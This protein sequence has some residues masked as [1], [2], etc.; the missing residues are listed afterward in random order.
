[1]LRAR[2]IVLAG[3]LAAGCGTPSYVRTAYDG[4][5]ASLQRDVRAAVAAGKVDRDGVVELARAVARR[6]VRSV[7][8]EYAVERI[9]GSRVCVDTVASELWER[10]RAKDDAGAQALLVLLES[11]RVTRGAVLGDHAR[12]AS[13]AFRAVAARATGTSEHSAL[14][15]SYY[16]D[17]DERVRREALRAAM[18]ARDPR[19]LPAL[20]DA[21][22]LDPAPANRSAAIRALGLVGDEKA[23]L[24]LVDLWAQADS[25]T[26]L[27]I[28]EAWAALGLFDKGGSG[29]LLRL[30]ESRRGLQSVSAASA[31]ARQGE[32]FAKVG[33]AVLAHFVADGTTDERLVAIQV[34][35]LSDPATLAAI[36]QASNSDDRTVAVVAAARLLEDKGRR[37]RAR[38]QLVVWAKGTDG[39]ARQAAAALVAV[40]DPSAAPFLTRD[41]TG[42]PAARERA[43]L[44]LFRLGRPA[45]MANTLADSDPGVRMGVACSLLAEG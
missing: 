1:M 9:R 7:K 31:L 33:R 15:A 14:R 4:N 36:T 24:A 34:A 3:V 25:A 28:V 16:V 30:A 19:D 43:A 22:R 20:L 11:G 40:G 45:L 39:A 8:G 26:R 32:P 10:A 17:P 23:T 5:L 37:E 2:V 35:P 42:Y 38:Q 18:E 27:A 12:S 41:L 13:G 44:G 6:E 29:E 21:A